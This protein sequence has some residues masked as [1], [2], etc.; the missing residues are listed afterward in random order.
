MRLFS[1]SSQFV[2]NLPSD[3]IP[4][5]LDELFNK[6]L[7]KNFVQYETPIDYLNHAIKS[8][9]FPG[10]SLN[11][12]SQNI[13]HGKKIDYRPATNVNDILT[14]RQLRVTFGSKDS[15]TNYWM[16]YAIF[17]NVYLREDIFWKPIMINVL[18]IYRDV[19][20]TI[21]FSEILFTD[22]SDNTFSYSD[23]RISN[24][25]FTVTFN[26]NFMEITNELDDSEVIGLNRIIKK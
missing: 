2:F 11:V 4:I 21:K 10:A 23:Q 26:F 18:D 1:Q 7:E 24:K 17:N 19:I 8:I 22:I 16:M 13:K 5:E 9:A 25:E 20:Y 12:V 15:D 6:M 3:F 14:T